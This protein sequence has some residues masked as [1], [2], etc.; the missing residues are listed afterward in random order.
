MY[1]QQ[2]LSLLIFSWYKNLCLFGVW[3]TKTINGL[4][5]SLILTRY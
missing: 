3:T 1:K 5:E 2:G 4:K